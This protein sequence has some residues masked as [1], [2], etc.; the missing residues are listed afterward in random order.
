[1]SELLFK[2]FSLYGSYIY[3]YNWTRGFCLIMSCNYWM[4]MIVNFEGFN[5]DCLIFKKM[6]D[7][8]WKR[9]KVG[10]VFVCL[11]CKKCLDG[12]WRIYLFVKMNWTKILVFFT[13]SNMI[14][15][16]GVGFNQWILKNF[17]HRFI[18]FS[19]KYFLK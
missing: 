15:L 18:W 17:S 16:D 5:V 14:E 8:V 2:I 10:V 13:W 7:L 19:K 12:V 1:M 11:F 4:M 6:F 9:L 3:Y